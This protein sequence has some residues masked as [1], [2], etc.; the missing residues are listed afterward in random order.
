[1]SD[2]VYDLR[3]RRPWAGG[4][5]SAAVSDFL[6]GRVLAWLGGAATV[7][8]IVLL[9]ALAVARGWIGHEARVAMAAAASGFLMVVGAWLHGRRG[10][11]EAAVVMVG[12]GS[13]GAFAT[14]LVASA[15]YRLLAPELAIAGSMAVGAAVTTLAI[16]WS[17]RTLAALGLLGAL[18]SP[19]LVS[20]WGDSS[21]WSD[22]VAV[23]L[24]AVG[25]ACASWV[26]LW[27]RWPWL[28]FGAVMLCAPQWLAWMV[29]GHAVALDVTVLSVFALLGLLAAVFAQLRA[30]QRDRLA[31]SAAA[32]ALLNALI[33]GL[34]ARL[35]LGAGVGALW[36]C[37]AGVAYGVLALVGLRRLSVLELASSVLELPSSSSSRGRWPSILA[38][39]GS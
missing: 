9:L 32:L 21:A 36:L 18:A 22:G 3:R 2:E 25:C 37:A 4:V 34:A 15:I 10:R 23:A 8:G 12:A 7:L 16:R 14:L 30:P 24:L 27:R 28:A 13:V 6:G 31:R 11:T 35:E 17:G 5:S 29:R 39:A 1:M 38:F 20:L 26:V 19:M 33:T